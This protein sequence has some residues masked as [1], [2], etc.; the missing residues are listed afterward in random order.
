MKD[1][2]MQRQS[3]DLKLGMGKRKKNAVEDAVVRVRGGYFSV[4]FPPN[5]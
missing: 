3:Y 5:L 2:R 4:I 1:E